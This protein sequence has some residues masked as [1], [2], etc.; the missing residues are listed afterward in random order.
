MLR[1][2]NALLKQYFKKNISMKK[3]SKVFSV[4]EIVKECLTIVVEIL[5]P[6]K[7]FNEEP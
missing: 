7:V 1:Q 6:D 5:D 3:N 2:E 4:V